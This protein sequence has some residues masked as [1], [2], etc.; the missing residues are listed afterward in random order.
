M[1]LTWETKNSASVLWSSST[2]LS[3]SETSASVAILATISVAMIFSSLFLSVFIVCA[4]QLRALYQLI[5]SMI[6]SLT[7][8]QD[9]VELH[10]I[11]LNKFLNDYGFLSTESAPALSCFFNKQLAGLLRT[12]C[13]KAAAD[14]SKGG[15]FFF[16]SKITVLFK[17]GVSC[18]RNPS[19]LP[20]GTTYICLYKAF[21]CVYRTF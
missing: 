18:V 1:W 12:R 10:R 16:G 2:L 6:L 14:A 19:L 3:K 9:V 11:I 7:P 21:L 4:N 15:G 17:A 13:K 20:I 8:A 5:H